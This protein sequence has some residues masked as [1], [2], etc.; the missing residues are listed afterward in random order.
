MV[1]RERR[2]VQRHQGLLEG[3]NL[4]EKVLDQGANEEPRLSQKDQIQGKKEGS[5]RHSRGLDLSNWKNPFTKISRAGPG[6]QE[7]GQQRLS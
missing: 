7:W 2:A 6:R 4:I 1:N 5:Q 3:R